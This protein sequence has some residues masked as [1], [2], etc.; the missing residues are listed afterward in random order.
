MKKKFRFNI[1]MIAT[2]ITILYGAYYLLLHD[3]F[4]HTSISSII[5]HSHQLARQNHVLVLGL[6]PVY[7]A[8]MIFGTSIFGIYLG[9]KIQQFVYTNSAQR[10]NEEKNCQCE[11]K[12]PIDLT[13]YRSQSYKK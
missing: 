2:F 1:I 9:A 4:L 10:Q 11:T 13:K 3:T 8:L 6:I 12:Q 5:A 7:I